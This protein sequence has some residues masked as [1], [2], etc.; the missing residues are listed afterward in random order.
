METIVQDKIPLVYEKKIIKGQRLRLT[1]KRRKDNN[2]C[3]VAGCGKKLDTGDKAKS[4]DAGFYHF[5][6][7]VCAFRLAYE[8]IS[9]FGFPMSWIRDGYLDSNTN[10]AKIINFISQVKGEF[11][12]SD[13]IT[14]TGVNRTTIYYKVGELLRAEFLQRRKLE[15]KMKYAYT[16]TILWGDRTA[17]GVL[18]LNMRRAGR[19]RRQPK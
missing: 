1:D 4:R 17:I 8:Y 16:K 18:V 11:F 14:G 12:V 15:H 10:Y 6:C 5:I 3:R 2:Y 19:R 13:I 7:K 9:H